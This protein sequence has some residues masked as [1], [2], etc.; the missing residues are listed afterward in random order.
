MEEVMEKSWV[1]SNTIVRVWIFSVFITSFLFSARVVGYYPS[2]VQN[3]FNIDQIDFSTFTHVIHS[4]AW[5]NSQGDI[6]SDNGTFNTSFA[7]HVQSHGRKFLLALGGWGAAENFAASTSTSELRS[8]FISNILEIINTYGYD[9]IDIDWEYPQNNQQRNNLNLFIAELD[10]SMNELN[11]GLLITM[12]VPISNWSGQWYDFQTLNQFVDFF[13][14]MTYDIHGSWTSDAGHNS[15]LFPSPP[16]DPDGSVSTGI[17]Y[18][19]N[20]RGLP[21]SKINIGI[22]F[23]GKKYQTSTIN[24]AF[25]GDAVDIRYSEIIDL[26]DN[27]WNYQWDEVAKCPYLVKEDQSRI[28]TYD[29]P[30]SIQFK[31]QYANERN[32]GGVMVWALGYDNITSDESLTSA[33]SNHWLGL[34]NNSTN[35]LADDFK[36]TT[37]PNPFNSSVN[38]KFKLY[39]K[40]SININI[41][42]VQGRFIYKVIEKVFEK[43]NFEILWEVDREINSGVYFVRLSYGDKTETQKILYLK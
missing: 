17:T 11:P 7:S 20:T 3:N 25:S 5:P 12:A 24:G 36:I 1:K 27:G 30:E 9:G 42:D 23:W 34:Q 37:Y 4:F 13:N 16:G 21:A 29:N 22:P 6:E 8:Y 10:S 28:I 43:G 2:W 32:L 19:I 35:I 15:P 31:C 14:A 41:F 33:I 39:Q 40:G 26:I 38:I 18:L